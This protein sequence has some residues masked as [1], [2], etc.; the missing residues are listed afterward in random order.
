MAA[1]TIFVSG[2]RVLAFQGDRADP[3]RRGSRRRA[4]ASPTPSSGSRSSPRGSRWRGPSARPARRRART[5]ALPR[6]RPPQPRPDD[7]DRG[8]RGQRRGHRRALRPRRRRGRP[9]HRQPGV[10]RR[11]VAGD[12]RA[13]RRASRSASATRPTSCSSA[14]PPSPRSARR[15]RRSSAATRASSRS[16]TSSRWC[17]RPTSCSSPRTPTSTT[18]CSGDDVERM[19][20][21]IEEELRREV[22]SVW[23]V[24]LDPTP[25]EHADGRAARAPRLTARSGGR[26]RGRQP[27]AGAGDERLRAARRDA[28]GAR[29]SPGARRRPSRGGRAR[30]AGARAAP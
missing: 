12:R 28:R 6:V 3:A 10:G 19:T 9:D 1:V 2:A 4:S 13:A 22:P 27:R 26:A 14:R 18:T 5:A 7:E 20:A 30:C 24:F 8:V 25:R 17:S 11:R 21:E 16:A 15:S 29:R 23:Q